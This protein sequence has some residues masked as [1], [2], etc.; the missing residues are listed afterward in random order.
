MEDEQLVERIL[1]GDDSALKELYDRYLKQIFSYAYL[2]T[3]DYQYAEEVTQDIFI[4]MTGNLHRFRGKSSFKTWLFTIGRNVVIDHHRRQKRHKQSISVKEVRPEK[5][6]SFHTDQLE[7]GL[8]ERMVRN[9]NKLPEEYRTVIHLRFIDDFSLSET[10]KIMSKTVMA[11]KA[12]QHRAKKR[13]IE[14]VDS[15]GGL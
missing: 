3:G 2:Q 4:K 5:A 7:E 6:G 14:L 12:L 9:L 15:E 10:A 13:F 1:D 11:I 8:S